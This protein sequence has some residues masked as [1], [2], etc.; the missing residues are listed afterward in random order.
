M[1]VNKQ[2]GDL[3]YGVEMEK[4]IVLTDFSTENSV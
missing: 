1:K 2:V 3:I 4:A